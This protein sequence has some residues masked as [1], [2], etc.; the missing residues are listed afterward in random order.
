M[1]KR[2]GE[3]EENRKRGGGDN[4]TEKI[5]LKNQVYS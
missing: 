4:I 1:R 2:G 3:E 5:F